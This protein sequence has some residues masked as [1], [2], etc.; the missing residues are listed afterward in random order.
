MKKFDL[1]K[2]TIVLFLWVFAVPVF[3]QSLTDSVV[4]SVSPANPKPSQNI[5][6]TVSSINSNINLAKI[7]WML[8]GKSM[9]SGVGEKVFSFNAP[10]AGKSQTLSVVVILTNNE[11]IEKSQVI[12][13]DGDVDL[14]FEAVDGYTPPFYKGKTLPIKQGIIK[15]VAIPNIKDS[16]GVNIPA[17][18]FSY[19]WVKDGNNVTTQS[20][21]G[22]SSMIFSN[23]ILDVGNTIKVS[24][25]NGERSSFVSAG[26]SFFEPEIIFYEHDNLQGP[27][28]YS[29][30]LGEVISINQPRITIVAEP[31]FLARNWR[32]NG[33]IIMKWT[34]NNEQARAGDKNTL[35]V[36]TDTKGIVNVGLEYNDQKKLFR[37]FKETLRLNVQ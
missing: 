13:S 3:G 25:T 21:L 6:A 16:K 23:Q 31:Y 9:K 17:K 19:S 37:N 22:K 8:D 29:K 20:G 5:V 4:L 7:S 27:A 35:G 34:L 12:T 33:D 30:A 18:N 32:T 24:V 1:K 26:V 36:I 10:L 15:A 28:R 2:L 11:R 14:I